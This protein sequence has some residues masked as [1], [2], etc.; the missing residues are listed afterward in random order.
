MKKSQS[1]AIVLVLMLAIAAGVC[2]GSAQPDPVRRAWSDT[3]MEQAGPTVPMG[4]WR[5]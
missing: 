4:E 2:M 3:T 5:H 1:L